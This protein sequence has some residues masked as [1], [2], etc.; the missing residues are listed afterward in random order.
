MQAIG[1]RVKIGE[2][3]GHAHHLATAVGNRFDLIES[4]AHDVAQR[5]V[6]LGGAT[7]S[8]VVNL[9][10][11]AIDHVVD[12]ALAA[13]AHAD[14]ARACFDE[15]TQDRLLAHDAAVV[16]RISRSGHHRDEGVQVVGAT[17]ARELTNAAKLCSNSHGIS[18]LTLA[19][20]IENR[21]VDDLVIRA[22]EVTLA[23]QLDDVGDGILRQKHGADNRLLGCDVIGR[24]AIGSW[25]AVVR[26]AITGVQFSN[27]HDCPFRSCVP[28]SCACSTQCSLGSV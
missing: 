15:S 1:K 14:N 23:H 28:V 17:D 26:L 21:A 13:V 12:I 5:D 18:R 27:A 24:S 8:D 10:L 11:R 7:I 16:V 6:I 4:V 3:S 20:K 22:V 2:T 25:L 9:G 19:V